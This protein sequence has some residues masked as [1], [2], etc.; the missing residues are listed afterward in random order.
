MIPIIS[1]RVNA[2]AHVIGQRFRQ[3]SVTAEISESSCHEHSNALLDIHSEQH[4]ARRIGRAGSHDD[5]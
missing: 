1:A 4:D 2:I 5:D 3:T